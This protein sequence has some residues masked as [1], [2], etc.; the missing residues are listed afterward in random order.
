MLAGLDVK[1]RERVSHELPASRLLEEFAG[2]PVIITLA[3][4]SSFSF[5]KVTESSFLVCRTP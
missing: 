3:F 4:I 1:I 2:A 5:L